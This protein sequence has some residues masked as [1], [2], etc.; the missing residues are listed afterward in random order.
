MANKPGMRTRSVCVWICWR[1]CLRLCADT[2]ACYAGINSNNEN[3]ETENYT[4]KIML[5]WMCVDALRASADVMRADADALRM[6]ASGD[7]LRCKRRHQ[8]KIA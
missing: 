4:C 5:E 1:A 2:C 3:R 7:A 6:D 8:L